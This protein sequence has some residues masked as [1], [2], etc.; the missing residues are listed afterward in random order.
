MNHGIASLLLSHQQ[1]AVGCPR[2]ILNWI[3][4]VEPGKGCSTRVPASSRH[5]PGC[6]KPQAGLLCSSSLPLCGYIG[7]PVGPTGMVSRS[8]VKLVLPSP[9]R[10]LLRTIILVYAI[11]FARHF[12]RFKGIRFNHG[13]LCL[14]CGNPSPAG[15]VCDRAGPS[16]R[17]EVRVC[18]ALLH[19]AQE[20]CWVT[21]NLGSASFDP[22]ASRP[23]VQYVDAEMHFRVRS[24]PRLVFSDRP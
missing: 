8:Q 22:C 2:A 17:Y 6:H 24:S 7:G 16:S 14:A 15:E 11:Q 19:C 20:K 10:W 5:T 4:F 13:G 18:Q 21:N 23:A 3:P 9:H 1:A 12:P